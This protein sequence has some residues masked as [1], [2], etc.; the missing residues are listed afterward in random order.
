MGALKLRP[1]LAF[2]EF[3]HDWS[4][5]RQPSEPGGRYD[6]ESSCRTLYGTRISS[7]K[8]GQMV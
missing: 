3:R 7:S 1:I 5:E 4:R 2:T 6:A 8:H